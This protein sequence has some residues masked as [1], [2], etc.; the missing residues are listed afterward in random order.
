MNLANFNL[1]IRRGQYSFPFSILLPRA[2]PASLNYDAGNY[3]KY[4]I[5]AQLN[6]KENFTFSQVFKRLL[7][8]R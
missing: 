1:G 3:I 7:H 6:S 5:A 4:E 8:I 2:F